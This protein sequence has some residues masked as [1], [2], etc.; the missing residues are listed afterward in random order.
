MFFYGKVFAARRPLSA[1]AAAAPP[2]GEL[3]LGRE[4][5][6]FYGEVGGNGTVCAPMAA[7]RLCV[8]ERPGR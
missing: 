6:L 8:A 3:G 1:A 7:L 4:G 2:T 5:G